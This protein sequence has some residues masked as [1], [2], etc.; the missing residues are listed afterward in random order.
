[1]LSLT[2]DDQAA[3]RQYFGKY[4]AIVVAH[5]ADA[6]AAGLTDDGRKRGEICVDVPG[7]LEEPD[8]APPPPP[9]SEENGHAPPQ[10]ATPR[11]LR[12]VAKPS[13]MPGF[14]FI[15]EPDENVWVEFVAGDIDFPIWTGMWYPTGKSPATVSGER[16]TKDQRVIRTVSGHVVQIDDTADEEKIVITHKTGGFLSIDKNGSVIIGN[17]NG[18]TVVLNA[19]NASVVIVD[20]SQNS[21]RMTEDGVVIV[22]GDGKAAVTLSGELARVTAKQIALE[23]TEVALGKDAGDPTIV[24]APDFVVKWNLFAAHTHTVPGVGASGP[25]L[26]APGPLLGPGA[27]L[28]MAVTVK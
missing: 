10:E 23:G 17:P 9:P 13:F 1:M 2:C 4:A 19:D 25:P 18:S 26:P 28:S 11:A 3:A 27:G 15:P 6:S 22:T 5:D 12:V 16:P 21:V 24:A 7:I 20:E 14:F 8:D